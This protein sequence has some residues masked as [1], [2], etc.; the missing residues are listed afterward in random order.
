[1]VQLSMS[2][3]GRV[4]VKLAISGGRLQVPQARK[5]RRPMSVDTLL[6]KEKE[7]SLYKTAG[8][9]D[10]RERVVGRLHRLEDK[11]Q[12]LTGVAPSG[13]ISPRTRGPEVFGLMREELERKLGGAHKDRVEGGRAD[14]KKPEDFN[15]KQLARGI[16]V[17]REHTDN[18]SLAKEIA[19][20]HLEEFP[21][22]Y[23]ALSKMEEGLKEAKKIAGILGAL[24]KPIP[25]TKPW[26]LKPADA[27][28]K[29]TGAKAIAKTGLRPAAK[30]TTRGG[31]TALSSNY[32][33]SLGFG[34]LLAKTG[35]GP[36]ENKL[37]WY[38][39]AA[40][41]SGGALAAQKL[42]PQKYKGVA[43]IGGALAG[44]ALGLEAGT[45]LGRKLDKR[46]DAPSRD[47]DP[48]Y[49]GLEHQA[50][51][52][53]RTLDLASKVGEAIRGLGRLV[54]HDMYPTRDVGTERDPAAVHSLELKG[55]RNAAAATP[56]PGYTPTR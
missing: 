6:R 31:T 55:T 27:A 20:D 52:G 3:L 44:T 25:G 47:E 37:P 56:S 48:S 35:A 22:Y 29:T 13:L 7:G 12:E 49:V 40:G 39:T 17:E 34:D 10:L 11:T 28:L 23:Q 2:P 36:W 21:G 54:G 32:M 41:A 14:D 4:L 42:V 33:R 43:S 53:L 26:F 30:A 15:Q 5:G 46:R 19:M 38:T 45:P 9:E 51:P 24:T 1:V 8:L 50:N 16:K 18:P